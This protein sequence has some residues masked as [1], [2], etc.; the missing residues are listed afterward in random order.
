MSSTDHRDLPAETEEL[1]QATE[2]RERLILGLDALADVV[3]SCD[4]EWRFRYLNAAG[5][6]LLG[7]L[8]GADD[9]EGRVVWEMVPQLV[10]TRF[11]AEVRRAVREQRVVEYFEYVEASH[12]WFENRIVPSPDGGVSAFSRDV[13]E[14]QR[15]IAALRVSEERYRTLVVATTEMVWWTD[16]AGQVVDMPFWRE[17]TGQTVEQ[18]RGDGWATAIH[19]DDAERTAALFRAAVLSRTAYKAQYRLRLRDGSYRWYRARGVPVQNADGSVREW[20][21]LFN[22][23]DGTLR[24][25]EGMRF[26]VEAS[27]ALTATLDEW[28][29]LDT[30]ARLAV[31]HLADG[32]MITL[33]REGGRFDHVTTR[34]RD[35]QMAEFA[36]ATE[37]LYPLPPDAPS[38]YPRAIRTGES[39][40]VPPDVFHDE[41]LPRIAADAIHLERLRRLEMYSAMVIPLV[42]RGTTLGAMTLVLLGPERRRPFDASDLAL[43]TELGRRAAL[44]ID[45]ARLFDAERL[46]RLEAA[47]ATERVQA[48]ADASR[49]FA[50]SSADPMRVV[51]ALAQVLSQR[52]GDMCAVR[53]LSDDGGWLEPVAAHHV[54]PELESELAEMMFSSAQRASEGLTSPLLRGEAHVLIP[55]FDWR[56][57]G[58]VIAQPYCDWMDRRGMHSVL[59]VAMR[60]NERVLGTVLLGRQ[61]A[62]QPYDEQDLAL[63]QDLADRATLV[64]ERARLFEAERSARA[65]AERSAELTRRLQEITASFARTIALDDVAEATLTHGL[66]T[67]SADSGMVYMMDR[68][69]SALELVAFRGMTEEAIA[70]ARRIPL[71]AATPVADA[72]RTGEIV[73]LAERDAAPE[74]DPAAPAEQMSGGTAMWV[75]LPLLHG[76][77]TLGALAL[78][79]PGTRDVSLELAALLDALARHCA[80]AMERARLLDAETAARDEA[81]R[82]NRAKSELLAKV[83]HETRQP[84]HATVGWLDTLE[85]ELHGPLTAAQREALRRIKQNQLRLLSVLNDLLDISRIEAGKLDLRM[86]DVVVASIVDAVEGAV[87][88]Q[89]RDKGIAFEFH[90]PEP[91][92][93]VRADNDQLVG[94]LT[95]LLSNAAKFTP[96]GGRVDVTCHVDDAHVRLDVRDTGIG[97]AAEALDRVFEPFFQVESGFTRTTMGTGLGLAISREAARAMSGEVSVESVVGMGSCFTLRLMRR[98]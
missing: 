33:L 86:V 91:S 51:D 93:R 72:V 74:R 14:R 11:E 5:R 25:D 90:R 16:A 18:V 98:R 8:G 96:S 64:L 76:G 40:L 17:L 63:V 47:R 23:V 31:D 30:L 78:V 32:A 65:R 95:N 87:A 27:A 12:R 46:A 3:A 48:V 68:T 75:A 53:L 4:A 77:R 69:E 83:S 22:E 28:A 81:E 71:A 9:Y 6:A 36:A 39:E 34:G 38:G 92:V 21:G 10:G 89:M 57:H 82:A 29:T 42:A 41:L 60:A 45:N 73:C 79:F 58:S 44:A 94:I 20:V 26:L 1:R 7:Q 35:Q 13:S 97:I 70:F 37:R 55:Q 24:R 59:A 49:A 88:L 56:Q 50:E 54:V 84:V 61:T 43:A 15:Q 80:Q 62:G 85:L 52:I 66:E 19:P 67:L 2:S